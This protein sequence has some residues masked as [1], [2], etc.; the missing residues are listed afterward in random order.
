MLKPWRAHCRTWSHLKTGSL[1]IIKLMWNHRVDSNPIWLTSFSK[2]WIWIWRE[3]CAEGGGHVEMKADMG[4]SLCHQRST[5]DPGRQARARHSG[6]LA[7][8]LPQAQ[9]ASWPGTSRLHKRETTH[10]CC[11]S[12]LVGS[13]LFCASKLVQ[14]VGNTL[15]LLINVPNS[16]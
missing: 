5:Q 12:H 10:C 6:S 11:F 9:P 8:S 14:K 7:A 15:L 1:Q 3:M 16:S 13:T 4:G 2:G